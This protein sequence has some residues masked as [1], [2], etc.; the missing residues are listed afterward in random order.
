M[1]HSIR[2]LRSNYRRLRKLMIRT[3]FWSRKIIFRSW[4]N[5]SLSPTCLINNGPTFPNSSTTSRTSTSSPP[6]PGSATALAYVTRTTNMSWR[7]STSLST[8]GYCPGPIKF[9][10]TECTNAIRLLLRLNSPASPPQLKGLTFGMSTHTTTTTTISC[11]L[12]IQVQDGSAKPPT[13]SQNSSNSKENKTLSPTST[14][15]PQVA[16]W[17][18][19]PE[20]PSP[21]LHSKMMMRRRKRKLSERIRTR[22]PN[23]KRTKSS[24]KSNKKTSITHK[25]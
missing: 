12:K 13:T 16:C 1:K 3:C 6:M 23:S 24:K 9:S 19:T 2:M 4:K 20:V 25:F 14:T 15:S 22:S 10:S 17:E 8:P 21:G 11:P 18:P 5:A 7:A